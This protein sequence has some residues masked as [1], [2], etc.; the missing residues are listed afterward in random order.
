MGE[1]ANNLPRR[2]PACGSDVF[3]F[4]KRYVSDNDYS[5]DPLVVYPGAAKA[6]TLVALDR[7]ATGNCRGCLGHLLVLD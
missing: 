2:Y 1:A 5:Q 6:A 4:V 3:G 7:L